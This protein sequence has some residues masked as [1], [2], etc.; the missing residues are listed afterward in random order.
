MKI[1]A[2]GK[3]AGTNQKGV[4][5]VLALIITLVVFL[6]IVSTLYVITASTTMSGVGKRYATASEAADGSI[7]VVKDSINLAMWGEQIATIF[8]A[9]G[10]CSE[11]AYNIAYAIL[12]ENTPCTT[13]I[14]LPGV[15]GASFEATVTVRRLYTVALPGG[16]LEFARSAGGVSST[17]IFYRITS[18]V[19]GKNS[20]DATAENSVLYRFAG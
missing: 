4:A 3:A 18:T 1:R 16:R 19:K 10:S 5:L 13:S 11:G 2:A 7:H 15:S 20:N 6:L 9:G 14:T 12:K 8:H 17:V